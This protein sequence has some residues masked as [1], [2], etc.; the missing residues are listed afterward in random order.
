VGSVDYRVH[1][2]PKCGDI[3]T[4]EVHRWFS[5]Y[6]RCPQCRYRTRKTS[7]ET[8]VA[9][10]HTHGGRVRVTERCVNCSYQSTYERATP[11][12]S[13]SSSSSGSGFHGGRGGGS[14]G[15]G[16]SGGGGAGHHF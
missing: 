7:R 13:D 5:G 3:R 16:H 1:Q 6:D 12:L 10:T 14:F 2:C 9:A 11:R 4:F 15:G 8:I